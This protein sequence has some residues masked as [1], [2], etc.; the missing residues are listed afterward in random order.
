M[1]CTCG[2][3]SCT[4]HMFQGKGHCICCVGEM[5]AALSARICSTQPRSASKCAMSLEAVL[6]SDAS[7]VVRGKQM[8]GI[9]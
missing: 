6:H 2:I 8:P 4:E 5:F 3:S 7:E 9:F 1:A